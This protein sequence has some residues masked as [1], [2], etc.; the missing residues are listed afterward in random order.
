VIKNAQRLI[1]ITQDQPSAF[2]PTREGPSKEDK[3][4]RARRL[5][6]TGTN[7]RVASSNL[8][9]SFIAPNDGCA[10]LQCEAVRKAAGWLLNFRLG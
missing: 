6:P 2:S 5:L 1:F 10:A 9:K 4:Q 8:H 3:A 7:S